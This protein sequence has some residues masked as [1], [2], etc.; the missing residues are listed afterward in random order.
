MAT[1]SSNNRNGNGNEKGSSL[2]CQRKK[3]QHF[4][5]TENH[6]TNFT[7]SIVLKLNGR[8]NFNDFVCGFNQWCNLPAD[9]KYLKWYYIIL[10]FALCNFKWTSFKLSKVEKFSRWFSTEFSPK[11]SHYVEITIVEIAFWWQ[12][13]YMI[14]KTRA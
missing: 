10:S 7:I 12:S 4:L 11:I 9:I 5:S 8:E 14:G 1:A 6:N 13:A 2:K 3:K